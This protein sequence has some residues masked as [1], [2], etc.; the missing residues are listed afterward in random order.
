MDKSVLRK[1]VE[2]FGETAQIDK[3]IEECAELIK[4]LSDYKF[5]GKSEGVVENI[6]TEIAD[7]QIM[8]AQMRLIFGNSDVYREVEQKLSYLKNL[9]NEHQIKV[10]IE[11]MRGQCRFCAKNR[12][13]SP[14][15]LLME[16]IEKTSV[17][18]FVIPASTVAENKCE[19]W[20]WNYGREGKN[21]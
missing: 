12:V 3:C 20:E 8:T 2:V 16:R 5:K 15:K 13:D 6:V 4:A 18:T 11:Q 14:C 10:A 9:V 21:D 7:V 17:L 19:E 1:A